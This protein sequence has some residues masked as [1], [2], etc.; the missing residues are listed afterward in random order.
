[1][2]QTNQYKGEFPPEWE[3]LAAIESLTALLSLRTDYGQDWCIE[4][5]DPARVDE[6][7]DVYES[8]ALDFEQRFALMALIIASYD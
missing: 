6:F 1:M 3:T 2:S 7:C 8:A 4:L 5:S